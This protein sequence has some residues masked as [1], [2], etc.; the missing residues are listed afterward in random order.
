MKSTVGIGLPSVGDYT[1]CE[2][3]R[4]ARLCRWPMLYLANS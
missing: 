4:H 2:R 1:A 3:S